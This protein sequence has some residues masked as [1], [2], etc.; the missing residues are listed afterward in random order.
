MPSDNEISQKG[1]DTDAEITD[2]N[3]S[4][5]NLIFIPAVKSPNPQINTEAKKFVKYST[6]IFVKLSIV[7][8]NLAPPL[9]K[10]NRILLVFR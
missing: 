5:L 4:R 9:F 3:I 7:F 8:A 1:I 2:I 6:N 10:T